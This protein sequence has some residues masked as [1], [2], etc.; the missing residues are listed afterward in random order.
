MITALKTCGAILTMIVTVQ[1]FLLICASPLIIAGL[2]GHI[3][4]DWQQFAVANGVILFFIVG[5]VA[6]MMAVEMA[7]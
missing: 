5:P 3:D 4:V 2:T 7:G 1:L 6:A